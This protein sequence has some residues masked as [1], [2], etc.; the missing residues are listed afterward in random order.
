MLSTMLIDLWGHREAAK[1]LATPRQVWECRQT[2][3]R[4]RVSHLVHL[5]VQQPGSDSIE[6]LLQ[7]RKVRL[8]VCFQGACYLLD[9]WT[10]TASG[11]KAVLPTQTGNVTDVWII[12]VVRCF[13]ALCARADITSPIIQ[14][15]PVKQACLERHFE[16]Q[17]FATCA[18]VS[19]SVCVYRGCT[20]PSK[21]NS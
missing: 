14:G 4:T 15:H 17:A 18:R 9:R 7:T 13:D 8:C 16:T 20:V 11:E 12:E 21:A 2:P 6:M 19:V 1:P 5:Q 3:F 10:V